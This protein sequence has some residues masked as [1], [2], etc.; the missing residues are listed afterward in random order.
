MAGGPRLTQRQVQTVFRLR[1][2][3]VFLNDIAHQLDCDISCVSLVVRAR[4]NSIG[5]SDQWTPR[6][7][8]LSGVEREQILAGLARAESLSSI[9]R[10]L[11]RSPS[12]ISPVGASTNS[13]LALWRP[14]LA[15][16]EAART[17]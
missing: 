16:Q 7:G 8:R 13:T 6:A 15:I 1:A 10:S 12:T 14:E 3:G 4:R 11:S 2:E 9:A 5:V 17:T